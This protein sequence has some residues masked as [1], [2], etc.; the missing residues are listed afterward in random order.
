ME[1]LAILLLATAF[2]LTRTT[3]LATAVHI[4]LAQSATVAA[5]CAAAGWQAGETHMFVAALLTV[6]VKAGLIPYALL[7][8]V[9]LLKR[10]REDHP[11]IGANMS[12]LA[13]VGAMVLAYALIDHALP[14]VVSRDAVATA[15]ALV[16]IGLML[17]ITRRQAIMQIVG[18]I[19]VEN[20]LYL[21]GLST[22]RGLPL[23]IELGIFFD[24]L[25]AVTVMVILT[26]R[27]KRSFQTTDTGILKR[28]KG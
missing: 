10:E 4:L 1:T 9:R 17:I 13:A 3:R 15:V 23:I 5:A 16:L 27:L 22:T 25:V 20:G 18:L 7:R 19:T 21:L 2:L 26:F 6:V 24:V 14:A 12:S 8:L 28:L 11:V